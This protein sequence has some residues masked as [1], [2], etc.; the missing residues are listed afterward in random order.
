MIPLPCS[1]GL[2]IKQKER[3]VLNTQRKID[4]DMYIK[5]DLKKRGFP[6][7]CRISSISNQINS[8]ENCFVMFLLSFSV[9]IVRVYVT[10]YAPES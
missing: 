8:S 5:K 1:V 9:I 4:V 3:S 10:C 2:K 6:N 7:I